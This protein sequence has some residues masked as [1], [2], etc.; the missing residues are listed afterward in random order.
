MKRTLSLVFAGLVLI[1]GNC[2]SQGST[3]INKLRNVVSSI[4]QYNTII[5]L[6]A[7]N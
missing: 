3:A 4:D 6:F 5:T 7:E 1:I 2:Y